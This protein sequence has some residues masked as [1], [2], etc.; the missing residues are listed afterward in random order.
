MGQVGLT[1]AGPV[2][3]ANICCRGVIPKEFDIIQIALY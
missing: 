2:V 3:G 1:I